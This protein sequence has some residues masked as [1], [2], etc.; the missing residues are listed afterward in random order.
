MSKN[1]RNLGD[2]DKRIKPYHVQER[3]ATLTI[4]HVGLETIKTRFKPEHN[5][6]TVLAGDSNFNPFAAENVMQ[7]LYVLWFV[8]LGA[9]MNFPLNN[10]NRRTLIKAY[11]RDPQNLIGKKITLKF[12]KAPNGADTIIVEPVTP[13]GAAEPETLADETPVRLDE[14]VNPDQ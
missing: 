6:V 9:R 2:L 8:E 14:L 10:T 4:S 11:G 5:A 12:G 1:K 13:R 7:D 3:P